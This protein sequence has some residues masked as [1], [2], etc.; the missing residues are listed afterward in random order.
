MSYANHLPVAS[1]LPHTAG[2]SHLGGYRTLGDTIFHPSASNP[3]Q[4]GPSNPP[5]WY[6][7]PTPAESSYQ[8]HTPIFRHPAPGEAGPSRSPG[9]YPTTR[10]QPYPQSRPH[11]Q[12]L[13]VD[14][15]P[16]RGQSKGKGREIPLASTNYAPPTPKTPS[17]GSRLEVCPNIL[18][19]C[20][21][22]NTICK[23]PIPTARPHDGIFVESPQFPSLDLQYS[24][25]QQPVAETPMPTQWASGPQYPTDAMVSDTFRRPATAQGRR[26]ATRS[27]RKFEGTILA[28]R[29]RPTQFQYQQPQP[30]VAGSWGLAMDVPTPPV[31][32]A[33]PPDGSPLHRPADKP[34]R[35]PRRVNQKYPRPVNVR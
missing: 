28:N 8:N 10:H 23:P 11:P 9:I 21:P 34:K 2:A 7:T 20:A 1:P 31:D 26:S 15:S 3:A 30:T 6:V 35:S 18:R 16:V 13:C 12:G 17:W 5:G 19:C 14:R 33:P 29:T 27:T 22:S 25:L 24:R 4:D 32:T